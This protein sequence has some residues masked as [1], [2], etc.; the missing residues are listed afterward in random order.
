M[1]YIRAISGLPLVL[2]EMKN[3]IAEVEECIGNLPK[4]R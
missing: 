3:A 2:G 1:D 4:R